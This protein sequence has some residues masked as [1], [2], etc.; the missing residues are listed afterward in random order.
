MFR[1][2]L[3]YAFL[4]YFIDPLAPYNGHKMYGFIPFTVM[5]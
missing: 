5:L 2:Q 4:S 3:F 1:A